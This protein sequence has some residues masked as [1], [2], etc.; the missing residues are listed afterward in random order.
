M[1]EKR[2]LVINRMGDKRMR[3]DELMLNDKGRGG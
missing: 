1:A 2:G 3:R